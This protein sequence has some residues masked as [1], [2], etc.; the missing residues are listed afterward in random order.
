ME[1]IQHMFLFNNTLLSQ[2]FTLKMDLVCIH[3]THTYKMGI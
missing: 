1:N 3:S 2:T